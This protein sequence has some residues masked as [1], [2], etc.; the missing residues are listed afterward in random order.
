MIVEDEPDAAELFAEMMRLDG[1]RV[2]KAYSG[3]PALALLEQERPD[4]IFL[5]VMMP[6]ISGLEVLRQIRADPALC[7]IPVVM[8]SARAMP[9]DIE[10]GIQAGASIYLTKP[11]R[12][13][14]LKSAVDSL[15]NTT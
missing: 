7:A 10:S 14:D 15:V 8:I 1:F 9:A 5:D 4:I 13:T 6:G 11:V 3:G 2:L 12:Y